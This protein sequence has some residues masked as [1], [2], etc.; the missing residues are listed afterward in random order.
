VGS[1][2]ITDYPPGATPLEPDDLAKLIPDLATR[3]DLNLAE[4]SNILRALLWA[5]GNRAIRSEL[6][7]M[8]GL[9]RLHKEMFGAV[10]TWAGQTRSRELN[11]GVDAYKIREEL[12]RLCGNVSYWVEHETYPWEELA[13]RFHHKLVWIHPFVNG[14]GRHARLAGDLLL[15]FHGQE[16]LPWGGSEG[17][18]EASPRREE[19]ITALRDADR[20]SFARLVRFA[21]ST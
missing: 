6:L 10:W 1:V 13:V 12:P 11:L 21:T 7:S 19:Y 3:A 18:V 16:P 5:R 2:K 17:L 8:H 4:Q 9:L 14:N 15:E 20:G